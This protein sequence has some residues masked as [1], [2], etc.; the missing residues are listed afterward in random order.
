MHGDFEMPVTCPGHGVDS[1]RACW[2]YEIRKGT[3]FNRSP[4]GE[5][6]WKKLSYTCLCEEAP[7][8]ADAADDW[9]E[10]YVFPDCS[11]SYKTEEAGCMDP[12]ALNYDARAG[13]HDQAQ[14]LKP[15]RHP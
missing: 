2:K 8:I 4:Y 15:F 7:H 9:E 6:S 11:R 12:A 5:R 13:R 14:A 1:G 10:L 3:N